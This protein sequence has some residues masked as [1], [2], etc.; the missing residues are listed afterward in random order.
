MAQLKRALITQP[1]LPSVALPLFFFAEVFVIL[2]LQV[3]P[4]LLAAAT[5]FHQVN[6]TS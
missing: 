6:L 5:F 2:Y 4:N 1:R 3:F